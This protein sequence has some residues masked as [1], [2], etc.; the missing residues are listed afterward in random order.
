M[1]RWAA[2]LDLTTRAPR[3]GSVFSPSMPSEFS[4]PKKTDE[5]LDG[6]QE[7]CYNGRKAKEPKQVKSTCPGQRWRLQGS[8]KRSRGSQ[9]RTSVLNPCHSEG[10]QGAWGTSRAGVWDCMRWKMNK[11]SLLHLFVVAL[12]GAAL[13]GC[14]P[15]MN[16]HLCPFSKKPHWWLQVHLA[17]PLRQR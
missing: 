2:T 1:V 13:T 14:A 10:R 4:L 11:V 7:S 15:G 6:L 12:L 3:R 16:P 8:S 5:S 9:V 17:R